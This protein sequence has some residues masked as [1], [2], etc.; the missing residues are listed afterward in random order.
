M[1][2][3]VDVRLKKITIKN[4]WK[5][6]QETPKTV[7]GRKQFE[8]QMVSVSMLQKIF[9]KTFNKQSNKN[10]QHI[11]VP[12]LPNGHLFSRRS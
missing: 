11:V 12:A 3:N 4:K 2:I 5:Q 7:V 8:I 1:S 10:Q 9:I 6:Q